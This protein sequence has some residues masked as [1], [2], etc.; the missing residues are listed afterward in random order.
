MDTLDELGFRKVAM[1]TPCMHPLTQL[2]ENKIGK[3]VLAGAVAT[4]GF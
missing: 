4:T 3:P 1:I 2:M